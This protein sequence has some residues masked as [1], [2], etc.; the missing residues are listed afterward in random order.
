MDTLIGPILP[1]LGSL[2]DRLRSP[3]LGML[4]CRS[5]ARDQFATLV[6]VIERVSG[7]E[8]PSTLTA[9]A[10]LAGWTQQAGN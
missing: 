9:R 6:P 3:A 8:H 7:A 1:L 4:T 5:A 10:N 2:A